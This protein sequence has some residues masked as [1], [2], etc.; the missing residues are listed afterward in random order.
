MY[1]VLTL[2]DPAVRRPPPPADFFSAEMRKKRV[3]LHHIDFENC[4]LT[5]TATAVPS[6]IFWI[7]PCILSF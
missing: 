6:L 2:A 7:R 3:L 1:N 4:F 5:M